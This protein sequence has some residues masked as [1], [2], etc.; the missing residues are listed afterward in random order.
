[1]SS[2]SLPA[3][4]YRELIRAAQS[5]PEQLEQLYQA[6]R[7]SRRAGQFTQDLNA[8][9]QEASESLL[10]AAWHYRLQQSAPDEWFA[11]V[12]SNWRLAILMSALLGLALWGLSDPRLV[13][14]QQVP[15]L[16]FLGAPLIALFL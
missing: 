5:D 6:A 14:D 9:Y 4:S 8:L 10:Y 3:E 1:M 7:R 15:S 16:A 2:S 12:G 13:I 11:R